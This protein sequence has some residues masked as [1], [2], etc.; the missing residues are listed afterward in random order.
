MTDRELATVEISKTGVDEKEL[1][2]AT[3]T[4]TGTDKQGRAVTF[5]LDQIEAGDEAT[6]KSG[7]GDTA[8]QWVS[9]KTPTTIKHIPDGTYTL[10]EDAAPNG[11]S[12]ATDITFVIDNAEITQIGEKSV[13]G[14]NTVV[15]NNTTLANLVF[16]KAD[17]FG[18]EVKGA[19][20]ELTGLTDK[21][22]AD[23][24]RI[25]VTFDT[26]NVEL[27]EDAALGANADSTKL[28]WTSGSTST[29]IKNLPD[30]DYILHEEAAPNGYVKATDIPFTI[31]NGKLTSVKGDAVEEGQITVQMIDEKIVEVEISK[32]DVHS[33]ELPGALLTLTGEDS[34]GAAISFADGSVKPGEGATVKSGSGT[35][36]Q[37]E[38]GTAPTVVT[39]LP[40][41]TYTLH[42]DTAPDGHNVA[43]D[44]V[45]V[46]E[47]GE[48]ITVD[49][50][51][52][53]EAGKVVMVDTDLTDVVFSKADQFG[54]EVKGATL[55]LTGKDSRGNDVV[56]KTAD[57]QLGEGAVLNTAADGTTLEWVSGSKTTLV[58]NLPDGSYLL[59]E[60][61]APNGYNKASDMPFEIKGG[62]LYS[63]MGV[64]VEEGGKTVQMI[65]EKIVEVKISKQDVH[66]Q[67]LQGATLTLTGKN[68]TEDIKLFK[69]Q[70]ELGEGAELKT[71]ED[72]TSLQWV[73]GT[74]PTVIHDL[75]D[76][77][78]K[79]HEDAAPDGFNVVTDVEFVIE[80]GELKT[81]NGE[82]PAAEGTVVMTDIAKAEVKISKQDASN[83]KELPGAVLTL[84]GVTHERDAENN[85]VKVVFPD[86]S[87][88]PGTGATVKSGSGTS[89]QWESG[90]A[91]TNVK[92][93]PDGIYTLHEDT[94]PD[95]FNVATDITFEIKNGELKMINGVE[96]E[97]GADTVT[98]FD[99]Q[100]IRTQISKKDQ[101]GEEVP[102][103]TLELTGKSGGKAIEFA[104]G[105]MELGTGAKSLSTS[106]EKLAWVS[107]T[108]ATNIKDLPDG[109]YLLHEE[110]APNGY[111]VANDMKFKIEGGKLTEVNGEAVAEGTTTVT[112]IDHKLAETK[113][114]KADQF[115]AEVAGATL[116][117]TGKDSEG[118][119]IT[120]P[121][122]SLKPGEGAVVT[123]GSG[124][125]LEWKSGTAP[126]DVKNLPDGK[127]TLHEDAA[128]N[129]YLVS[130]DM[131]FEIEGGKLVKINGAAVSEDTV[132]TMIDEMIVEV[133]ISK[134]DQFGKE[135]EGATLIL[136]GKNSANNAIIFPAES[137]TAG[138]GAKVKTDSGEKLEWTSGKGS[139]TVKNL[140]DGTYTLHEDAAPNGYLVSHDMTF[141]IENG[142][143]VKV[144]GEDYTEGNAITMIDERLG[145]VKIAKKDAF[146]GEVEGAT[147]TLTGTDKDGNKVTFPAGSVELGAGAELVNGSGDKLAWIS[148]T[149]T[150]NVLNLVDGIYTLHEQTAPTGFAVAQDMTFEIENSKIVKINGEAV[151]EGTVVE[152]IDKAL[153]DVK[154][155]KQDAADSKE[156]EGATMQLTGTDKDGNAVEFPA[157]SVVPGEGA[158][159]TTGEGTKLEWTSGQ[160]PTDIKNL[161]DGTYVLHEEVAPNGYE[162][163]TDITFVI[164]DGKLTKI[165]T[166][167]VAEGENLIVMFDDAKVTTTVTTSTT[168]PETT[169][170]EA[171]TTTTAKATTTTAKATTTTAK[172]TTTTPAVTTTT[173]APVTTTT[174]KVTTT[175]A[176]VTTTT[177][178][179]TTTTAPVTTTTA[180]V[181]TTTAPVTTTTA[182]VTT[183]TAPVTTTTAKVTTTTAK[184]TTTTAKVTT[185]T[186][187]VTTTTA[188]VTT[189]TAKV[190]TT[191]AKATT[192]APVTTTAVT[193][194]VRAEVKI[195]KQDVHSKEIK[196]AEL[197][198]TGKDSEGHVITFPEN[199]V[200]PG[201]GAEVKTGSGD[202]LVWISGDEATQISNLPDGT[203]TLHEEVAPNG[204]KVATDITFVIENS[205][206]VKVN[207]AEVESGAPVVMIDEAEDIVT[208][209]SWVTGELAEEANR[210]STT[211]TETTP[212][213][214]GDDSARARTTAA[215]TQTAAPETQTTAAP[216][217]TT[218]TVPSGG[219][220]T[221][222]GSVQTGDSA[223]V[224]VMVVGILMG[225]V[226]IALRKRRDDD[227]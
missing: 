210:T 225:A 35:S 57:V 154:I 166:E 211:Q 24:N 217:T 4:L 173:T 143:V 218:Q 53:A 76:G 1:Q 136:T 92:N 226:A 65:D 58:K 138:E 45:F 204:Y 114:N 47:R 37:W 203:Y 94:A 42:E 74:T 153:A 112:V 86:G 104:L 40:D 182:K 11:Y 220:N 214:T 131:T 56:F 145:D 161:V 186:A 41:G 140:A 167:T 162:V 88:E 7:D 61:S 78:Y 174:A 216:A 222:T 188:K 110:A 32:Q 227:Q 34:T 159:L 105:C 146:G 106:G 193:T 50:N 199:S 100:I 190:T 163:A 194:T 133:E 124:E 29:N 197:T 54:D 16:S 183:T 18:T 195:S 152:M 206:L 75:P 165:G 14:T 115:G 6:V 33:A 158:V 139:T 121:E 196:G 171:T 60:E 126:T 68:G 67:E 187:K 10:H 25:P 91:P 185:T 111:L 164:E 169:T 43:T 201:S 28:E 109:E 101:F 79:L 179:V 180:K 129:G 102:G 97:A 81:V 120:F 148:G 48:L 62:K 55:T 141:V 160:A 46:I 27:G 64:P 17:Q 26:V 8:A 73:S 82:A 221:K 80:R 208:T 15:M 44:I 144:N 168:A 90:T 39:N 189:T 151:A 191:T 177:A 181:T 30:G 176:P 175:T 9:G 132:V 22:D 212:A 118:N 224:A 184:V 107:G 117:L 63:V 172:A 38:S 147:L 108:G 156:L 83:H 66:S 223:P 99:D 31:R 122:G 205:K 113:I 93:L 134:A 125:K 219:V 215:E 2:G 137:V 23:G 3:L 19:K 135:V 178:K 155:S 142:K 51:A 119:D 84:T 198:L 207:D 170:T 85:P 77:T 128:P 96:T 130:S 192:T 116:I 87:V 157:G 5:A 98:M 127:Y 69:D 49:G 59:H 95:G 209:T 13:T 72:G 213:E 52:P 70:A 12:L 20:M 202:K 71:T 200:K 123:S 103:A 149:E 150:T 21:T 89:L 36:L